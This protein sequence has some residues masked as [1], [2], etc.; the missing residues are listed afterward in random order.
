MCFQETALQNGISLHTK[1]EAYVYFLSSGMTRRFF[2]SA[3]SYVLRQDSG[4][5]I[6]TRTH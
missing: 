4:K 5:N 6:Y 3:H 1:R 2:M